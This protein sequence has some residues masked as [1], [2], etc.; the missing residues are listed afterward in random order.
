MLTSAPFS[1][2]EI[3]CVMLKHRLELGALV[4]IFDYKLRLH[5][6]NTHHDIIG[7]KVTDQQKRAA[8]ASAHGVN[9]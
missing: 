2:R 9:P 3:I 4:N 1:L 6:E 7:Q 5:A 8:A